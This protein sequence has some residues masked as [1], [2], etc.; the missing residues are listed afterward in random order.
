MKSK[1]PTP[2][3]TRANEVM[4]HR[5]KMVFGECNRIAQLGTAVNSEL[6]TDDHASYI[7]DLARAIA[8]N[9][10]GACC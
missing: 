6:E 5:E 3:Y 4:D 9:T 10:K 1:K 8:Y 7:V 2:E